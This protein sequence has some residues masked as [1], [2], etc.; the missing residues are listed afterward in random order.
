[1]ETLAVK[2]QVKNLID[3]LDDEQAMQVLDYAKSL[4]RGEANVDFIKS[5]LDALCGRG[6][7]LWR[8]DPQKYIK[9]LRGD[10]RL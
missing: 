4:E 8:Q 1:M 3:A 10:D 2:T 7:R 6:G 9:D 5:E